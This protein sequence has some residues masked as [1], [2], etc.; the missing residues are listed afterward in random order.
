LCR[1]ESYI[2]KWPRNKRIAKILAV[3]MLLV[4]VIVPVFVDDT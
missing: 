1:E 4:G 3:I 2:H